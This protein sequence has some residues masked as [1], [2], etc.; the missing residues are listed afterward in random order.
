[1]RRALPAS[2]SPRARSADDILPLAASF[3]SATSALALKRSRSS[4]D[5]MIWWRE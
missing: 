1:L 4:C 3:F 5:S 2:I